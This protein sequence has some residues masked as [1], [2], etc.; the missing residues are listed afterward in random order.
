[1]VQH[2]SQG[3][4][5]KRDAL[6]SVELLQPLVDIARIPDLHILREIDYLVSY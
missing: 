6:A 1:M 5:G 2:R 4:E 3:A